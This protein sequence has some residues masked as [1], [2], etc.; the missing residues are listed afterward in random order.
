MN[1]AS[2][3]DACDLLPLTY[4]FDYIFESSSWHPVRDK[5]VTGG[6]IESKL[7]FVE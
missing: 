7:T 1:L 2:V 3:V 5:E 4:L 6:Y